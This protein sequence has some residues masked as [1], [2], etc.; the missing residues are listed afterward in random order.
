[1]SKFFKALAQARHDEMLKRGAQ[2]E[3]AAIPPRPPA[4]PRRTFP[5]IP[6]PPPSG[7]E[8]IDEHL[9]SLVTPAAFEAEQYRA[10]RH[11][12]EHAHRTTGLKVVAV[13]SP[14]MGDGKTTT[15]INLAGALAQAPEARVLLVDADLRRPAVG[16]L[17]DIPDTNGAD[18]SGAFIDPRLT[19]DRIAQPRPPFNLSVVAAGVIPR[20]PLRGPEIQRGSTS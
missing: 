8:R 4:G 16:R 3:H 19:L 20:K 18:L 13:S 2:T 12:V 14:G 5:A 15:A 17:L 9:V 6:Y 7:T 1:M 11:I 10:L